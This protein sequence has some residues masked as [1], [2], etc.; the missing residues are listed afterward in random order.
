LAG[1]LAEVRSVSAAFALSAD[2][3]AGVP[4]ALDLSTATPSMTLCFGSFDA[5]L[6][7]VFFVLSDGFFDSAIGRFILLVFATTL[8]FTHY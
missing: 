8:L 6:P 4:A 2:M 7:R 1:F 5:D 3:F